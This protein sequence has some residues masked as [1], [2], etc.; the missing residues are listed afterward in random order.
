MTHSFFN[1]SRVW[2]RLAL[3]SLMA[4]GITIASSAP[5]RAHEVLPAIGDM[6]QSGTRLEFE[7]RLN[8]EGFIAGINLGEATDTNE[9]AEAATYDSLRALSPDALETRFT[10]FWPQMAPRI[11]ILIDGTAVLPDLTNLHVG[12]IGNT[13]VPR[14]SVLRF[15][16]EV[17]EGAKT[18]Q[19]G[20][21]REFGALV[22][23]QQGVEKPYDG[24]LEGG[25]LSDPIRLTGGDQAGQL[26]TF[27]NY[28][29]VGFD[30]IVPK[31]LDHILFVLGLFFLSFRLRPLLWQVSAFTLAHT[32][33]LALGALGYV[34]IPAS[35]VEPVIAAS[36]TWVAVEN[37]L[38]KGVSRWR[39]LVVFCFGL[40]HGLGFASVLG[41]F[42]LP[43][44][45]FVPALL[46]FNVGVELGQL[47]VIAVAYLLVGY[48][49]GHKP[50]YR[51]RIAVPASALIAAT[52]AWWV[53]E[54]VFL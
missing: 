6:T 31:G 17:P 20:W 10:A 37:I 35:I 49:F 24:F 11:T 2:L 36:I 22:L 25:M 4:L 43:E 21:A 15:S 18:V 40:L 52:G 41:E 47:A 29:P 45:A 50:W 30:H 12:D 28:I 38:S 44:N 9:T 19:M 27:V 46:G 54:R 1:L 34:T 33:T 51:T 14:A 13:E 8:I 48:A 53:V 32:V 42:G 16:A 3:S 5:V 39:P 23:R 7:I 26:Q